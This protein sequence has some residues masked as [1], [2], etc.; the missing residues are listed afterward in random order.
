MMSLFTCPEGW[1][2]FSYVGYKRLVHDTRPV[3]RP[4]HTT[5]YWAVV[6]SVERE[7]FR[8]EG[9]KESKVILQVEVSCLVYP[10]RRERL[11]IGPNERVRR[12]GPSEGPRDTVAGAETLDLRE[13]LPDLHSRGGLRRRDQSLLL[14][15]RPST[16]SPTVPPFGHTG[17]P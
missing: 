10:T 4:V 12:H 11:V 6:R 15:S 3:A 9:S 7:P 8:S 1:W 13:A 17:S 14:S 16:A 2:S 5:E